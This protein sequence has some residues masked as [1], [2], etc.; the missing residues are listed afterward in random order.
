[1]DAEKA[2]EFDN[3]ISSIESKLS[4]VERELRRFRAHSATADWIAAEATYLE[5]Q[6]A[7]LLVRAAR[8]REGQEK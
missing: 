5:R 1:M 6:S 3:F 2:L 7:A 4:E 8:L